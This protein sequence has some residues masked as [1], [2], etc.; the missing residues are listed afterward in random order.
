MFNMMSINPAYAGSMDN[1]DITLLF[2]KQWLNYPG[3]PQT[4][5]FNAHTPFFYEKMGAGISVINDKLGV[6]NHNVVNLAYAYHVR[7]KTTMLSFGLQATYSQFSSNLSNIKINDP[8]AAPVADLTFDQNLTQM[9]IKGGGGVFLFGKKGYAGVSTPRFVDLLIKG[10]GAGTIVPYKSQPHVFFTAGYVID[11]ASGLKL[12]PSTV[13]KY[14][15]AAPL[16]LDLNAN[17]YILEKFGIGFS[18]RTFDSFDAII[19]YKVNKN[20]RLAY[21]YDYT[22]TDLGNYNTGSHEIMLNWQFGFKKGKIIT[23][24]YF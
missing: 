16:E 12:K 9:N 1:A 15:S 10:T 13:V 23:P 17:L 7:F 5:S 24:R 6:M 22:L 20:L 18:W 11:I 21:A 2:R 8:N 4:I 3:A 14:T 19:E